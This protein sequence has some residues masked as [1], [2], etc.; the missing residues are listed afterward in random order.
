V[1][2]GSP[3]AL[4]FEPGNPSPHP[5]A[6]LVLHGL[7]LLPERMGAWRDFLLGQGRYVAQVAFAGHD[8]ADLTGWRKIS[9]KQ[10][11]ED[12]Q[13]AVEAARRRW[14]QATLSLFG[15]SLGAVAGMVWSLERHQ[16][17]HR[18]VFLA[19]AFRVHRMFV[20]LLEAARGLPKHWRVPSLAP[21]SYRAHGSTS[22]AAFA[23]LGELSGRFQKLV[24]LHGEAPAPLAGPELAI[25]ARRD[26]LIS[27]DYLDRYAKLRNTNLELFP[28]QLGAARRYPRH[29][30][31]DPRSLGEA[32][33][34]RVTAHVAR[35]LQ[36]DNHSGSPEEGA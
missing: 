24:S 1:P 19:P 21:R 30:V 29:L 33:W 27:T 31:I 16:P 9:S 7:N 5:E 26:E 15:Y 23:A 36:R 8:P 22:L 10:W 14:P 13:Q 12:V 3:E 17:W 34:K 32:E 35:W 20:P 28:L 6:F 18:A 2:N 25:F 11:L 4:L